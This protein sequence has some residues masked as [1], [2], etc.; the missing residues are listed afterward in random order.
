M[1]NN[2]FSQFSYAIKTNIHQSNDL[3]KQ[4]SS[5]Y[6]QHLHF[7]YKTMTIKICAGRYMI[8]KR[9]LFE[10]I[11]MV[12]FVLRHI[13]RRSTT[14]KLNPIINAVIGFRYMPALCTYIRWYKID[15]PYR[16]YT[17]QLKSDLRFNCIF[18]S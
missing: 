11:P 12:C 7:N 10:N 5:M 14:R 3:A 13:V 2:E 1:C 15:P 9:K 18:S 17:L 6:E 8:R 4:T 16:L